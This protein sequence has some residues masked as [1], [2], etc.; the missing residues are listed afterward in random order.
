VTEKTISSPV[1]TPP[2]RAWMPRSSSSGSLS[3]ASRRQRRRRG[4]VEMQQRGG[5]ASGAARSRSWASLF[6]TGTRRVC[7]RRPALFE[8][9]LIKHVRAPPH[10]GRGRPPRIAVSVVTDC[11]DGFRLQ[12]RARG[13]IHRCQPLN[14]LVV[15]S[16][17]PRV[18]NRAAQLRPAACRSILAEAADG[19]Q[20]SRP[21]SQQMKRVTRLAAPPG[22]LPLAERQD[23]RSAGKRLD[24]T[25][26]RSGTGSERAAL[27]RCAGKRPSLPHPPTG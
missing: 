5:R 7:G 21:R 20:P 8:P 12:V 11:R 10:C 17:S 15:L 4:R 9:R 19:V 1:S 24:I 23:R 16:P 14:A 3:A 22:T 2:V 27:P 26:R 18:R 6:G 25:G 13:P